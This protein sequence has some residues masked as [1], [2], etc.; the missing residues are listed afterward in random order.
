MSV[1]DRGGDDLETVVR[2]EMARWTVP[3]LAVATLH[4]GATEARGFGVISLETGYP[5]LADT[6]FRV[7]SI[8]K[9][10]TATL[11]MGLVDEGLLDLDRPVIEYLPTLQLADGRARQTITLRHLLSHQSGLAGDL[12]EDHGLGEDALERGVARFGMLRQITA[13]GELWAY[14]NAGFHLAGAIIAR[15]L[16]TTFE[17]AMRERIFDPLGLGRT[18]FFAHEAIVHS[19]AVGHDQAVP[20]GDEH[21]VAP[22]YYPR[23]RNPA[24]GI[25]STVGDLLAFTA[26]H[27]GDGRTNGTRVLSEATLRAMQAPQVRAGNFA[28]AYGLGWALRTVA[29]VDVIGHSGSIN[30]YESR[31][32]IVPERR[33]AIAVLTNSG[34]GSAAIRGIEAWALEHYCGLRAEDAPSVTLGSGQLPRY[35]GRYRRPHAAIAVAAH[36]G[37]LRIDVLA[38]DPWTGEESR[39]P[40]QLVR[41]IDAGEFVVTEGEEQGARVDFI[42]GDTGQPRFI[43][44]GGRLAD[45]VADGTP[46][47]A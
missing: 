38:K 15:V 14:C 29:G 9:L 11:A 41:P 1:Y 4:H 2:G 28:D 39:L 17:A 7:A 35:T 43:R 23:N 32:T 46:N 27:L 34:R 12:F 42:P 13:P 19:V 40:P 6:L 21:R 18:C 3:G 25:I 37:G 20:G 44:L 8:S 26:L 5:I 24:G 31:L 45:R 47:G 33:F 22:Q 36:G 16:G 30:G 10:F